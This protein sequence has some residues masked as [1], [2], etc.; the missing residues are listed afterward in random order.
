MRCLPCG[1]SP[2]AHIDRV[3]QDQNLPRLEAKNETNR[4]P[5]VGIP[6][7]RE[8]VDECAFPLESR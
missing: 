6:V 2:I 7:F 8:V 3:L 4:H 5:L 1:V